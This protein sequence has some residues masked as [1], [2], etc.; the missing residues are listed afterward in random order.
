VAGAVARAQPPRYD[1]PIT[2]SWRE[3]YAPT[4]AALQAFVDALSDVEADRV[5]HYADMRG[6]LQQIPLAQAITHLVNH[7]TAHRA[8]TGVLL[9]RLGQSPGETLT[10]STF[11]SS[12]RRGAR[13]RG[14]NGQRG[15]VASDHGPTR[16]DGVAGQRRPAPPRRSV[17]SRIRY[18]QETA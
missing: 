16:Q 10:T 7:G 17:A 13:R 1:E 12:T 18:R 3:A 5:V 8:E 9:E 14:G 2:A 4:H 6:T 15:A 11:A